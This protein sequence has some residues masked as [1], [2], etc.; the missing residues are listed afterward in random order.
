MLMDLQL[1]KINII[2]NSPYSPKFNPIE[3]VFGLI[4][5]KLR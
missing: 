2:W 1:F 4:K 3:E 5:A